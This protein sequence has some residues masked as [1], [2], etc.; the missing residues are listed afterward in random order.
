MNN[1]KAASE[2]CAE[3]PGKSTVRQSDYTE[4]VRTLRRYSDK[5]LL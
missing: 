2:Q 3:E 1:D 4:V 5:S